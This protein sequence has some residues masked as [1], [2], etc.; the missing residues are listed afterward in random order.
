[1]DWK[2][3]AAGFKASGF[4][5]NRVLPASVL[6][7]L[8]VLLAVLLG[9][10]KQIN[11]L[12]RESPRM[13]PARQLDRLV[14]NAAHL[15]QSGRLELAVEELE[16]ARLREPDNLEILDLLAQCYEE[17][18]HFDRARE[19]YDQG[20]SQAGHHQALEN[21]RCYSLY[22]QGRLNQAEAC[23]RKVLRRNPDNQ[24]ARN[25][26]GL[27]LCRQT[28]EAEA[29]A[30]WQEDL[31]EAEAR[32]LLGQA[33]ATL[34][35]EVPPHLAAAG[36]PPG[37]QQKT[38][39]STPAVSAANEPSEPRVH[40]PS[41][42]ENLTIA[43][44]QSAPSSSPA[45]AP[46]DRKLTASA[47]A[48]QS[49][50][51]APPEPEA[52]APAL[53]TAASPEKLA[54]KQPNNPPAPIAA[55]EAEVQAQP[56]KVV[57][58]AP[59]KE[60]SAPQAEVSTNKEPTPAAT[61]HLTALDLWETKIELNNGNG[62]QD[63]ARKFRSR[64][65]CEGFNVVSIGNHID[66]GLEETII[67]HR[68]EADRVAQVLAQKFFPEAKLEADGKTSPR[69]DIRVSLGH[70]LA[71]AP[72]L[73]TRPQEKVA[74]VDSAPLP[75][76]P[77][78]EEIAALDPTPLL[79]APCPVG[80]AAFDAAPLPS[81]APMPPASSE[82]APRAATPPTAPTPGTDTPDFLAAR[83]DPRMRIELRNGNGVAGQ[84]RKM[85]RVLRG[86]GF[87]VINIGNCKDYGLEETVIAFRPEAAG[88]A[89]VLSQ[90]FFSGANLEEKG[91]LPFWLDIRV[92][93][94]Q[95]LISDQE[96]LAQLTPLNPEAP[97]LE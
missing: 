71:F 56:Q 43:Q 70:D 83:A 15:R 79:L 13:R 23:F 12:S 41:G 72:D 87:K 17:L 6:L 48:G 84:A 34:G 86:E 58:E 33:L 30:L 77:R 9:C 29:L 65:R 16:E 91:D 38:A 44:T 47:A 32:Q 25:N 76:V 55:Q 19:V 82:P 60:Q 36:S 54:A 46:R 37:D 62:I 24:T 74:A 50:T 11:T 42:Q 89:E 1:M 27:V 26:L 69:A 5:E 10:Q 18:G 96:Q 49:P 31:G 8:M 35:R 61:P 3:V 85:R 22:L 95:D 39:S 73:P 88:V 2:K 90:K 28:R 78:R 21:N 52:Q 59:R 75:A 4:L 40:L 51:E 64:L 93:M 53:A 66:F 97:R 68:P 57:A 7:A 45:A 80:M 63:C 81:A 92:L 20:L 14:Q 94:G 67:A